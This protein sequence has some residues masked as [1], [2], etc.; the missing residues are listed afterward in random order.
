MMIFTLQGEE[1]G[2]DFGKAFPLVVFGGFS[3][4]AGC[5]ALL[6]PETLHKKLPETINDA[7][8]FGS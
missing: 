1:L 6:L 5:L 7:V 2:G 3:I 8:Q 4:L